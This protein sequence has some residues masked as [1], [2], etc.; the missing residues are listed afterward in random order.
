[1]GA[2]VTGFD[3]NF[4][5]AAPALFRVGQVHWDELG[6]KWRYGQANGALTAGTTC[7]FSKDGTFDA[8]P[9]TTTTLNSQ[10]QRLCAPNIDMT[11]NYFGWFFCG[12]GDFELIIANA[13]GAN[14]VITSTATAGKPGSG[15]TPLDGFENIDAGVTDTRVTCTVYGEFTAGLIAAYD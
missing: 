9:M 11:D 1:M 13:I 4:Q 6:R 7:Q 2:Q 14:S 3:P 10:V 5:S 12:Y 8:T 15:G